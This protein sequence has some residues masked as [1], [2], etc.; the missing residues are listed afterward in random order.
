MCFP[1]VIKILQK[2]IDHTQFKNY[3]GL[4]GMEKRGSNNYS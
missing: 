2:A 1:E 3:S 4:E